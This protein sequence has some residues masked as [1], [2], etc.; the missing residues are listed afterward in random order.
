MLRFKDALTL[1]L[2]QPI[3]AL[4]KVSATSAAFGLIIDFG[5]V[6][7]ECCSDKIDLPFIDDRTDF[8]SDPTDDR[9]ESPK[10]VLLLSEGRSDLELW[11]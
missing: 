8:A 9:F 5:L 3:N 4:P 7:R 2:E 10:G 11:L 6:S 1:R